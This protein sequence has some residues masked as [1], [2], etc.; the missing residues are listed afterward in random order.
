MHALGIRAGD[1]VGVIAENEPSWLF[2]DLGAQAIG[3]M[4]VAAYPTQIASD[5]TYVMSHAAVRVIFCG[6]QEQVDKIRD[7]TASLPALEKIVVFDMKGVAEYRDPMIMSFDQ[8]RALGD[9]VHA[10]QPEL[11][12]D[13]M[14]RIKPDDV[15]I[16]RLHLGHHRQAEGCAAAPP[17]PGRDG[18]G[19]RQ[20][21][22][23]S[24]PNT[25]TCATSRSAIPP[26]G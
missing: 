1:R 18:D 12:L 8:F 5:I 6:D 25:A 14:R 4:S 19:V 23:S 21:R 22:P 9:T 26:F 7:N 13:L 11:F 20:A 24:A 16:R 10:E 2:A 15:A 17:R 3:A